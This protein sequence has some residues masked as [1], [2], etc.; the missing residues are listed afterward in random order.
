MKNLSRS[1]RCSLSTPA[2]CYCMAVS[3]YHGERRLCTIKKKTLSTAPLN[4]ENSSPALWKV[5]PEKTSSQPC[6]RTIKCLESG[7]ARLGLDGKRAQCGLAYGNR[8]TSCFCPTF[9]SHPSACPGILFV[10]RDVRG[11]LA[12][13]HNQR[14]HMSPRRAF[15]NL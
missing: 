5:R 7:A 3:P 8:I 13:L 11:K 15:L 9:P 2:T 1:A 14:G 6:T 10:P 12:L 4:Y